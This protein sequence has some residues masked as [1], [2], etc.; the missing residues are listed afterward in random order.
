MTARTLLACLL[1]ITSLAANA[2]ETVRVA[3]GVY[4]LAGDL[5]QRSPENLGHNMTSGFIVT[6]EGVVVIDTGGSLADAQAIHAAIRKVTGAPVIFAVNTGGQDHRWF[7]NDYFR[8]QGARIAASEAALRD[9]RERG[10]AQSEAAS[11][12][13][14]R[15]IRRHP[16]RLPGC[17]LC[18]TAHAAGEKRTH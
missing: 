6:S 11:R 1:L 12:L 13:I 8:G 4:A 9:M 14:G 5:G 15:T 17:H 18:A 2:F 10:L 3:E 7:G 16:D